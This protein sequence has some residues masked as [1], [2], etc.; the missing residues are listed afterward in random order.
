MRLLTL[1]PYRWLASRAEA[2]IVTSWKNAAISKDLPRGV[3]TTAVPL[4]IDPARYVLSERLRAAGRIW[5]CSLAGNAPTIGFLGRHARYKG[6]DV[7]MRA[8]ADLPGV[9][10]FIAGDGAERAST[11]QLSQTLGLAD[12]VHF[13]GAIDE[14]DKLKLLC[15]ID[16]FV[17]PS[18][19][20]TEAFGVSQMEAMLC[21][22]PVVATDLPTGVTDVAI[23]G[24]TALLA[25]PGCSKSLKASIAAILGDRDLA[26]R[27]GSAGRQHVLNN[28]AEETVAEMACKV[29][30]AAASHRADT[31][32]R[33]AARS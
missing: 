12:R 7:L 5:R 25:T 23:D 14:T 19:E 16:A 1:W 30:E 28:M 33:R 22:V 9:H 8:L 31:D 11:E 3:R 21:G 4:G 10:A 6:L 29:I 17:F 27:L 2:V 15:A 32:Y 20:I 26:T 18:T 24:V 13:L